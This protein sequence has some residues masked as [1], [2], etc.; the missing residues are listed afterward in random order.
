MVIVI[1]REILD[2]GNKV[3][4][5]RLMELSQPYFSPLEDSMERCLIDFLR[6]GEISFVSV[7][8]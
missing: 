8:N 7:V 5:L 6:R 2:L 4:I 1:F 3:P